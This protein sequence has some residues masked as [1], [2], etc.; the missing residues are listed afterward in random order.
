MS[1]CRGGGSPTLPPSLLFSLLSV[2]FLLRRGRGWKVSQLRLLLAA[3]SS[4]ADNNQPQ[5]VI[6]SGQAEVTSQ[7]SFYR[8]IAQTQ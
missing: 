3:A 2:V 6:T 5:I 1:V 7:P 4:L 8:E